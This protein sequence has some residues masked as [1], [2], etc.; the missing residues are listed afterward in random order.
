MQKNMTAS[1][2]CLVLSHYLVRMPC[3]IGVLWKG[4]KKEKDKKERG[5]RERD[6]SRMGTSKQAGVEFQ[7]R[8]KQQTLH[9]VQ[10][11]TSVAG[12]PVHCALWQQ[13]CVPWV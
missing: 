4:K 1:V 3:K 7:Q 8:G 11:E 6:R 13:G 10:E 12:V 2:S 9:S 5:R